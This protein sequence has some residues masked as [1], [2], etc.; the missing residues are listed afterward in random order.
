M[1]GDRTSADTVNEAALQAWVM[2]VIPIPPAGKP[3]EAKQFIQDPQ[4]SK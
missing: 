2:S 1:L 3:T 4:G